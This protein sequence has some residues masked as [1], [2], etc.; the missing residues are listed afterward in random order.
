MSKKKTKNE[1]FCDE[2][3]VTYLPILI[4]QLLSRR[5]QMFEHLMGKNI[6]KSQPMFMIISLKISN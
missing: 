1:N 2:N 4:L 3:G 5:V 6:L